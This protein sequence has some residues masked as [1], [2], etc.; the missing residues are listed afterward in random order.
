MKYL[1]R[2]LNFVFMCIVSLTVMSNYVVYAAPD[3]QAA[4]E[5]ITGNTWVPAVYVGSTFVSARCEEP[6]A[7]AAP[8]PVAT[9]STLGIKNPLPDPTG[10]VFMNGLRLVYGALGGV[11]LIIVTWAGLKYTLSSGD[12]SKTKEAKDQIM[13]AGIG[14]AIAV[15]AAAITEFIIGRVGN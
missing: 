6:V 2:C 8:G 14:I 4:C 9:S 13:Y 1:V 15:S 12:P 3:N 11:S 10:D 5:K 7:S